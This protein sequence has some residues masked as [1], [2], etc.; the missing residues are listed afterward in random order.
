M[1]FWSLD[2]LIILLYL[3]KL[4]IIKHTQASDLTVEANDRERETTLSDTTNEADFRPSVLF[5]NSAVE[6]KYALALK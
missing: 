5:M 3:Q 4:H 6:E 1:F 2:N